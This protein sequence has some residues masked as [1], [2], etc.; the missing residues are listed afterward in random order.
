MPAF[1]QPTAA[2]GIT[3][4]RSN[5][6]RTSELYRETNQANDTQFREYLQ[7]NAKSAVEIE[8]KKSAVFQP[9][10]GTQCPQ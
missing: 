10:F 7:N 9:Y 4:Y 1:L 6:Q 3:D 2:R 8:R 5:C